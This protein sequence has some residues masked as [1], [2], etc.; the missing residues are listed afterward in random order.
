[1]VE[2]NTPLTVFGRVLGEFMDGR[3]VEDIETLVRRAD[4]IGE[5][6][7]GNAVEERMAYTGVEVPSMD[8]VALALGLSDEEC[9]RLAMA[10]TFEEDWPGPGAGA[11]RPYE[12]L[13]LGGMPACPYCGEDLSR[14]RAEV[15]WCPSCGRKVARTHPSRGLN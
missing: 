6:V 7:D 3:G 10:Y 4:A 11:P 2:K 14:P 9:I 12:G 13:Y 1:M 5:G 8:G 15:P